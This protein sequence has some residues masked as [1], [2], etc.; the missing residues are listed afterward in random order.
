MGTYCVL[1]ILIVSVNILTVYCKTFNS[2]QKLTALAE[3][4]DKLFKDF[5]VFLQRSDK[6]E[7]IVPEAVIRFYNERKA[8]ARLD[9][10]LNMAH[11]IRAFY[12]I[13]R[14]YKDW[15][16]VINSLNGNK[17][18]AY[19]PMVSDFLTK[20]QSTLT[21]LGFWPT[22]DDV[23]G[24]ADN[25]LRLWSVYDLDIKDIMNGE[26]ASEGTRPLKKTEV[27]TIAHTANLVQMDYYH[28][29]LLSELLNRTEDQHEKEEYQKRMNKAYYTA[30]TRRMS[31][32]WV[33]ALAYT[34]FK[35]YNERRIVLREANKTSISQNDI[36][37]LFIQPSDFE[38]LCCKPL[39]TK[40]EESKLSC[41]LKETALPFYFAKEEVVHYEPRISV[42]YDVISDD[43][44]RYL[45][46][47][48]TKT[49]H[50]SSVGVGH[51]GRV[52]VSLT[53]WVPDQAHPKVSK[54]LA[55]RIANIVNL[56]TTFKSRASPVEHW[57]VVSYSTGGYFNEHLDPNLETNQYI[58]EATEES[59]KYLQ[60]YGKF[61][62]H[63]IATWMLYLSDVKAGGETVFPLLKARIPVV[64]GAA[65][66]WY[67]LLPS[68]NVDGRTRHG[69]CP[70][71]L[72]SKWV[73]NK[74][75]HESG[76]E[77]KRPCGKTVDSEDVYPDKYLPQHN[78]QVY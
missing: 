17:T 2:I 46:R 10:C 45:K 27:E 39:K 20:Y 58:W 34:D 52:R 47:V 65:A 3:M 30:K 13:H 53:S 26:V 31:V 78:A 25:I 9:S 70:V 66:F 40:R 48:A 29:S 38:K 59:Q 62:G 5:E 67:N 16:T 72:G 43:D 15:S 24:L 50:D 7:E 6:R 4:E 69:G 77:F 8:D 42:F 64:K 32:L 35:K 19:Q 23:S 11:P 60:P 73:S 68:G 18:I 75:I 71:L 44:I 22:F 74:W 28:L 56:D 12:I 1:I 57:Q 36:Y 61:Q 21:K 55:R 51:V 33:P 49:L 14:I 54:R 41:Y 76:Q 63:R 37:T